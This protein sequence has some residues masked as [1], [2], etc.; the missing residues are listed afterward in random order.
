MY[1]HSRRSFSMVI[2]Y[3]GLRDEVMHAGEETKKT[4]HAMFLC[5]TGKQN[6]VNKA[7]VVTATQCVVLVC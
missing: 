3:L 5:V 2:S 4:K 7:T 1:L 6:S